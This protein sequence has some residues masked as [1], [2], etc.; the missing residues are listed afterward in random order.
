[1]GKNIRH[2]NLKTAATSLIS[3]IIVLCHDFSH[4]EIRQIFKII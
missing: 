2:F 4:L 3:L 1:M